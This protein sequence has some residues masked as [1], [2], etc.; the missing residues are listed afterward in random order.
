VNDWSAFAGLDTTSSE[1]AVIEDIFK[2]GHTKKPT[3]VINELRDSL[4]DSMT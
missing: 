3:Y 2:L 4:I 1:L